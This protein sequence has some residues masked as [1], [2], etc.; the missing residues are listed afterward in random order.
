[1]IR[2][3]ALL[4]AV[5]CAASE[6]DRPGT[7]VGNPSLTARIVDNALQ[8]VSSGLFEALEVHVTDCD[9]PTI[10]LGPTVLRFEGAES[11]DVVPLPLGEH[12][13]M[14]FVVDRFTVAFED[15]DRSITIVADDFDLAVPSEFVVTREGQVVLQFGNDAWLAEVA[16]HAPDGETRLGKHHPALTR[17]FFAGLWEGSQVLSLE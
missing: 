10:P 11:H 13:G 3:I 12:C 9:E 1:M 5:A 8:R 4:G 6:G 15:G 17:A 2:L 7:F 16:A 14:F